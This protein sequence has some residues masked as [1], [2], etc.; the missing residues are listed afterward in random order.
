MVVGMHLACCFSAQ[1]LSSAACSW[2]LLPAVLQIVVMSACLIAVHVVSLCFGNAPIVRVPLGGK[3]YFVMT[4]TFPYGKGAAQANQGLPVMS[5]VY[6]PQ[7]CCGLR[8]SRAGQLTA[9]GGFE[10]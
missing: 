1:C 2:Q 6:D 7:V 8:V 3:F 5:K 9:G 4:V 10:T